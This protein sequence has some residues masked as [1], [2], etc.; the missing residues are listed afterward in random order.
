LYVAGALLIAGALAAGGIAFAL[1]RARST[2]AGGDAAARRSQTVELSPYCRLVKELAEMSPSVQLLASGDGDRIR[3]RVRD[4]A[5]L[6]RSVRSES[7][8]E[9]RRSVD[10]LV[11][12]SLD[13]ARLLEKHRYDLEAMAEDPAARRLEAPRRERKLA[14]AQARVGAYNEEHCPIEGGPG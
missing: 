13:F 8:K 5:Q 6:T 3:T 7:P 9:L 11:A 1:E 14:A 4:W 10:V 12:A 2:N